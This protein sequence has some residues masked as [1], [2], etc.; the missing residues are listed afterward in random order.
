VE[1]KDVSNGLDEVREQHQLQYDDVLRQVVKL[2]QDERKGSRQV[3]N[4]CKTLKM[5]P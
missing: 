5:F 3:A 1:R 4:Q 2:T